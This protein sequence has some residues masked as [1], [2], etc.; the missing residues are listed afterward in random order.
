MR[1][2]IKEAAR[3]LGQS[4]RQIRYLITRGRLPAE[5]IGG[6]WHIERDDLPQTTGQ[7]RA[8]T[9]KD[10]RADQLPVEHG[11]VAPAP[12]KARKPFTV[13]SL[14]A[15]EIGLPLHRRLVD[16]C[17]DDHLAAN[18]LR[19]ALTLLVCGYHAFDGQQK[20]AYYG[21]AREATSRATAALLLDSGAAV[22]NA[23]LIDELESQLVPAIGGLVRRAER[24]GRTAV[25]R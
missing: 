13:R 5:K 12:A 1:V 7:T 15:V 23:A 21:R 10:A 18:H 4:E 17:G 6:R 24:R 3:L 11:G 9:T 14:K 16:V 2:S 8:Q 22:A 19:E 25:Q 20:G